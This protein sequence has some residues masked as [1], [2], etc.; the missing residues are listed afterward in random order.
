MGPCLFPFHPH[1]SKFSTFSSLHSLLF[2]PWSPLPSQVINDNC[3]FPVAPKN[4]VYRVKCQSCALL[5]LPLG[6][7]AVLQQHLLSPRGNWNRNPSPL[8]F[9]SGDLRLLTSHHLYPASPAP[10]SST[11]FFFPVCMS[12][13]TQTHGGPRPFSQT[14][15]Q[16]LFS[17]ILS[18]FCFCFS[19][20]PSGRYE[21][22]LA[23]FIPELGDRLTWAGPPT[24]LGQSVSLKS[25]PQ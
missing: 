5:Q 1:L 10:T 21:M 8:G 4:Q 7:Q 3:N 19:S 11:Y 2:I 20:F 9:P 13:S 15:R 23:I 17:Q 12:V 25:P 6:V 18:P 22:D 14:P 24:S 16:T